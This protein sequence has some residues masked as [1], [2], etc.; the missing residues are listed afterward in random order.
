MIRKRDKFWGSSEKQSVSELRWCQVSDCSGGLFQPPGMHDHQQWTAVYVGS[1]AARTTTGD[2][3]GWNRR[4]AACSWTDT[5]APDHA[6]IG[7]WAPC[8]TRAISE[9]FRDK[10][11]IIKRYINSPSLLYFLLLQ[12]TWKQC[13]P[14]TADSEG[15][16]SSVWRAHTEKI[17]V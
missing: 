6:G 1:L 2:G 9:R 11:L 7:K 4:C 3:G 14:E 10:E 17:D 5:V 13:I 8:Y 16:A 15:L 12:P